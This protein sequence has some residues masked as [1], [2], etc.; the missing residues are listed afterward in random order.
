MALD[1]SN[2]NYVRLSNGTFPLFVQGGAVYSEDGR[3]VD[4]DD[5]PDW[6]E[7]ELNK[8]SPEAKEAVGLVDRKPSLAKPKAPQS[9][10]GEQ[11]PS[12]RK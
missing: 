6:F 7:E 5:L 3:E 2:P 1:L 4:E 12:R 9:R 10:R 11:V 8:L